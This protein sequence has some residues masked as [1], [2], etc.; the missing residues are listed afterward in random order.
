MR[1]M[2]VVF[3]CL[4]RRGAAGCLSLI[5]HLSNRTCAWR[6]HSETND[7]ELSLGGRPAACKPIRTAHPPGRHSF[8]RVRVGCALTLLRGDPALHANAPAR[9]DDRAIDRT[10]Q[11]AG[12]VRSGTR[13]AVGTRDLRGGHAG[14]GWPTSQ[15]T[16]RPFDRCLRPP[17]RE[18][19][20]PRGVRSRLEDLHYAAWPLPSDGGHSRH[21]NDLSLP[22]RVS[23]ITMN[24]LRKAG[25]EALLRTTRG[26]ASSSLP[27]RKVAVLGAAGTC[28]TP[29]LGASAD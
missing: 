28:L 7:D 6:Y 1:C 11:R 19:P 16:G 29:A 24:H 14:H 3:F 8:A 27:D 9:G 22:R 15:S 23:Y 4:L 13:G 21:S 25:K 26:F 17:F 2:S 18:L 12:V 20:P 5:D 10:I